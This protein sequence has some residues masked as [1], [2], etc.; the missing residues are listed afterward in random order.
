MCYKLNILHHI[1]NIIFSLRKNLFC[2][3]NRA[4]LCDFLSRIYKLLNRS[5]L[6]KGKYS[7]NILY[8]NCFNNHRKIH[9]YISIMVR[10]ILLFYFHN[11]LCSC[12]KYFY[13]FHNNNHTYHNLL[14][15]YL[16]QNIQ[17]HNHIQVYFHRFYLFLCYKQYIN[18]IK[19]MSHIYR[20]ILSTLKCQD[21]HNIH[22][23][24][25]NQGLDYCYL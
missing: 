4:I 15:Y 23:N 10:F 22:L 12:L 20:R 6:N 18:R 16:Y 17:Y 7:L 14:H 24:K 11:I 3:N 1:R 9:P 2:I 8:F 5:K 19:S 21:L 13:N 25:N